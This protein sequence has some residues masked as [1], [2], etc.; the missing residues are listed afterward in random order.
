M[1]EVLEYPSRNRKIIE[2]RPS[3]Q[4]TLLWGSHVGHPRLTQ[5]YRM[6]QKVIPN[7]PSAQQLPGGPSWLKTVQELVKIGQTNHSPSSNSKEGQL[8]PWTK[9]ITSTLGFW[10]SMRT[11]CLRVPPT[12]RTAFPFLISH[13][14]FS[15]YSFSAFVLQKSSSP[16]QVLW[17]LTQNRS[18]PLGL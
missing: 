12:A 10:G 11:G 8:W 13:R 6:S 17:Y 4:Y 15:F 7:Q 16:E 5:K 9:S 2:K 1:P 14:L 18:R 3:K